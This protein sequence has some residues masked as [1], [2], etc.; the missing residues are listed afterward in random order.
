MKLNKTLIISTVATVAALL[1][2][3]TYQQN[4]VY[5]TASTNTLKTAYATFFSGLGQPYGGCGVPESELNGIPYVALNVQKLINGNY[6]S[7]LQR[8]L[9]QVNQLGEFNNGRNC[10]RWLRVNIGKFCQGGSN[11]G[12]PGTKFCSGGKLVN[13]EFT[14]AYQDFIVADSCQDQNMWCRDDINHLDLRESATKTFLNKTTGKAVSNLL[15]KWNNREITWQY[16]TSPK[17]NNM[18]FYFMK[19]AFKWWPAIL[20]TGFSNGISK[21]QRVVNG[22][23]KE[24]FRYSD[25]G[26]AFAIPS[27]N[28]DKDSGQA[29]ILKIFD[30]NGAQ[31]QG[32]YTV[33]FPSGCGTKCSAAVT[34]ATHKL[35][36]S[37]DFDDFVDEVKQAEVA[38]ILS[39]F[40]SE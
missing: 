35:Q 16:V 34:V 13:D 5:N 12:N 39:K 9:T 19:D 10:G 27:D 37:A 32:S 17:G 28:T 1:T 26:Q 30:I 20:I 25:M 24:A 11:T 8:P 4:I 23:A 18:K 15:N 33:T 7:N 2:Q 38:E 14:G 3:E 40:L 6:Y 22:V 36:S 31:Y 21:V 29:Y